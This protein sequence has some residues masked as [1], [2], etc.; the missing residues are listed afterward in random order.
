MLACS[1]GFGSSGTPTTHYNYD[2]LIG[3][4][5][6]QCMHIYV[7]TAEEEEEEEVVITLDTNRQQGNISNPKTISDVGIC[8]IDHTH[9]AKVDSLISRVFKNSECI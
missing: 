1:Y 2:E 6:G 5:D 4:N 8:L 9:A 3:C 7:G